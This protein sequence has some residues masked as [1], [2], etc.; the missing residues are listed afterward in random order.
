MNKYYYEINKPLVFYYK[1]EDLDRNSCRLINVIN[2][3]GII[4]SNAEFYKYF[5]PITKMHMV[6]LENYES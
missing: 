6:I 3:R 5:K 2:R 4:V 1:L